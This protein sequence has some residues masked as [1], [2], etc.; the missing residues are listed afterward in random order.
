MARA[1]ELGWGGRC[2]GISHQP[3]G[4]SHTS[5]VQGLPGG[6]GWQGVYRKA[7]VLPVL[8]V[9]EGD[10]DVWGWWKERWKQGAAGSSQAAA[11]CSTE[12]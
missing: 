2:R 11:R 8:M 5:H 4:N 1:P 12:G 10:R 9:G 3:Q 6:P 7:T